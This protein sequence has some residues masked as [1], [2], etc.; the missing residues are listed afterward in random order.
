MP[1]DLSDAVVQRAVA[2]VAPVV[3][4]AP[5]RT[6]AARREPNP[7]LLALL[8]SLADGASTAYLLKRGGGEDNAMLRGLQGKPGL[9]GLAV[10]GGGL[11]QAAVTHLIGKKFPKL[12]RAAMANQGATQ[13]GLAAENFSRPT[14]RSE[15]SI[16]T[17]RQAVVRA[18]TRDDRR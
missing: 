8:G 10:A 2:Q 16:D 18:M 5:A 17:Y 9:T 4:V 1:L 3:P 6:P 12:G 11:A 7:S 13:I 15:S 14:G